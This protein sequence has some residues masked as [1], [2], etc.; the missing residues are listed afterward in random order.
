[1]LT[2]ILTWSESCQN[3]GISRV[4]DM[5]EGYSRVLYIADFY[6][7]INRIGLITTFNTLNP[8]PPSRGVWALGRPWPQC[9]S[10][11]LYKCLKTRNWKILK[12]LMAHWKHWL[13]LVS[14]LFVF[15]NSWNLLWCTR[16]TL[17][18]MNKSTITFLLLNT[19]W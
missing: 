18:H 12:P 13:F 19:I 11:V 4:L 6:Y 16:F 14:H 9:S 17:E 10:R 7:R 15:A 3:I 1:M 5:L 2:R 8:I